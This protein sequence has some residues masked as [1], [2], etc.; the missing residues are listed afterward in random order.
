[1]S[2]MKKK[3]PG[4]AETA[5]LPDAGRTA[6]GDMK[7][8]SDYPEYCDYSCPYAGF[9]DAAAVGACRRDVGVWCEAAGRHNN[10]HTRCIMR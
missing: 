7:Y 4:P 10:K 8:D 6:R 5:D 3:K 9:A 2:G 1:M